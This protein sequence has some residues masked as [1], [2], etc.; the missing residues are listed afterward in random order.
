M[1]E[2]IL[3]TKSFKNFFGISPT[4]DHTYVHLDFKIYDSSKI[5][6]AQ[7]EETKIYCSFRTCIWDYSNEWEDKLTGIRFI[8]YGN[9]QWDT[10]LIGDQALSDIGCALAKYSKLKKLLLNLN[11]NEVGHYGTQD[12]LIE[13]ANCA[14]LTTLILDLGSNK[15]RNQGLIRLC[16]ALPNCSNL[17][18]I[19]INLRDNYIG[20]ESMSSFNYLAKLN[21]LSNLT[22]NLDK[23]QI[24]SIGYE[25]LICAIYQCSLQF[26]TLSLCNNKIGKQ[27]F[28][29]FQHELSNNLIV[30]HINLSL[31]NNCIN[32]EGLIKIGKGLSQFKQLSSLTLD[33]K[34]Y[35]SYKAFSG[36]CTILADCSN[37]RFLKLFLWYPDNEQF[38]LFSS[39]GKLVSI[40]E[41]ELNLECLQ[42]NDSDISYLGFVIQKLSKLQNL[43]LYLKG[44]IIGEEGV[45]SLCESLAQ[46]SKLSRLALDLENNKINRNSVQLLS[47]KL[48]DLNNLSTL[49]ICIDNNTLHVLNTLINCNHF[50]TL[51]IKGG[52]SLL[53]NESLLSNLKFKNNNL[54]VLIF[55][56]Q[57]QSSINHDALKF[58]LYKL[59]RA[60]HIKFKQ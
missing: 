26:L 23:N 55:D 60:V 8:K 15:V 22:I 7:L 13:L 19:S 37:L 16:S 31:L 9:Q 18:T 5:V 42:I 25:N 41:L 11:S 32:E 28:T 46:C 20:D 2:K 59:K 53:Q 33:I 57:Y 58:K 54:R 4:T 3:H 49:Q 39:I 30:E 44:N 48:T 52:Y 6:P 29:D 47:S 35:Y 56:I 27:A 45:I 34:Y 36:L 50:S 10:K 43:G 21:N 40:S 14:H 17:S 24:G 38:E 1:T 12:L 51:A